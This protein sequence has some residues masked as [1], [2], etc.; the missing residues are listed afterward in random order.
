MACFIFGAGSF[1]GLPV[2]PRKEDYVIA[3]DGGWN[4][5]RELG[6]EP[7]LL[8]GDFDSMQDVPAFDHIRRVPVE[9]DDTDMM[10]AVKEGLA[11]HHR[12]F[13]LYGGMGGKRSDHTIANLQTLVYLAEH[14]A[15][16]WLY[17]QGEVYTAICNDSLTWPAR[18]R[19]ILSV[20]C[21]GP[22]AEG[23][24]IT[25][26]KYTLE[27]ATLTAAFPLGVSNHFMGDPVT[28]SVRCGCLLM[29]L[30]EEDE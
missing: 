4:T 13:H 17:G 18:E 3:A 22:D 23:V 5:C 27:N 21:I 10:L 9:K 7:D 1:Y 26:G 20:F 25:G 8:L 30:H 29:G 16:G 14:A 11:G 6:I 15:R 24:S 28:V 19:G 2:A 12:E